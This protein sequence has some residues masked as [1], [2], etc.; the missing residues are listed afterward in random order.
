MEIGQ[1]VWDNTT[2]TAL[3]IGQELTTDELTSLTFIPVANANGDA[4]T[5]SYIVDDGNDENNSATQ[6]I[7]IN[8]T[9]INDPPNAVDDGPVFTTFGNQLT[10]DVLANDSDIDGPNSLSIQSS[11]SPK[12]GIVDQLGTQFRYRAFLGTGTDTFEYIVTDSGEEPNVDTATV[13]VN[14]IP[15][16]N[17]ADKLVGG[18]SNDNFDGGE[19][20]DT[21]EGL[22]GNDTLSGND[23][24]DSLVGGEGNDSIDGGNGNDTFVGG[25]G[26]DTLSD[27][28]GDNTFVYT[29]ANDGGGANFNAANATSIA[30]AIDTGLFDRITGFDGLGDVGGDTLEFSSTVLP[31]LDNIATNVQTTDISENVLISGTPGLF[32]YEVEGKTYLIYD[33]TGDNTVNDD[34]KILAELDISR[35]V[36]VD[37]NDDFTII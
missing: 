20:D 3:T 32:M 27:K 30:T 8:V 17:T 36:A 9:P 26:A 16:T 24:N 19:G 1:V 29:S 13:T 21:L 33:A 18:E 4:G 25:L 7:S 5:F 35:V 31:S 34:S 23:G 6:V 10:I 28:N 15:V 37:V 12:L 11:D 14:V 2:N 22:G